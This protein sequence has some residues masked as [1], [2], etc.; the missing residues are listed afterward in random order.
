MFHIEPLELSE[1]SE[2]FSRKGF[3]YIWP[4]NF[5]SLNQQISI[6]F[7]LKFFWGNPFTPSVW[8]SD[9][10]FKCFCTQA[11][12]LKIIRFHSNLRSRE[13]CCISF[14]GGKNKTS[15]FFFYTAHST[16]VFV[17]KTNVA[18]KNDLKVGRTVKKLKFNF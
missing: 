17:Q 6:F 12:L 18:P 13:V 2:F 5:A 11:T 14:L 10:F 4:L 1:S 8:F 3:T 15:L 16:P 9:T 7:P